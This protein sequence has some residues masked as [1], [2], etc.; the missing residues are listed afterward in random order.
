M[1]TRIIRCY[2]RVNELTRVITVTTMRGD[3]SGTLVVPLAKPHKI[4]RVAEQLELLLRLM[5]QA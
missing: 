5:M 2:S 3:Q 1:I 4:I